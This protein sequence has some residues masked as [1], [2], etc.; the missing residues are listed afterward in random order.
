MKALGVFLSSSC[1]ARHFEPYFVV[2]EEGA[3]LARQH[4]ISISET[5]VEDMRMFGTFELEPVRISTSMEQSTTRISLRL[6]AAPYYS[7][8]VAVPISG[9]PRLLMI[10]DM[11]RDGTYIPVTARLMIRAMSMRLNAELT[12]MALL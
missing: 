6:Q 9:F 5:M 7:G 3:G 10:E 12:H 11:A 8:A 1:L 2:E 4:E